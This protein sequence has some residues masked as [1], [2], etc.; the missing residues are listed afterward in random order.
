MTTFFTNK[1]ADIKVANGDTKSR[2]VTAAEY[3]DARSA[4]L[5][6]PHD[7]GGKTYTIMV[8][9]DQVP[10]QATGH[11]FTLVDSTGTAIAPAAIDKAIKVP[12]ELL[13]ATAFYILASAAVGLDVT[14]GFTKQWLA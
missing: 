3:Q 14:F 1:I 5:A 8:T 11:W 6:T 10:D 13:A 2:M 4:L 12:D 7:I 9:Y